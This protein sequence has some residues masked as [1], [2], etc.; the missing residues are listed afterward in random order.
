MVQVLGLLLSTWE[1]WI[2]FQVSGFGLGP[3][4]DIGVLEGVKWGV[5]NHLSLSFCVSL[6][7]SL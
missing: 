1:T 3:V 2:E 5:K 7:L 6:S 4:L